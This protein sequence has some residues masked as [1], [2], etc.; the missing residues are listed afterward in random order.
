M[1]NFDSLEGYTLEQRILQGER[2]D[3]LL[4]NILPGVGG[5][6]LLAFFQGRLTRQKI[7]DYR[8]GRRWPP[9]W[10]IDLLRA[11]IDRQQEEF[12]HLVAQIPVAKGRASSAINLARWKANRYR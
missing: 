1:Q 5:N 10:T 3:K 6:K 2:F 11:E 7:C 9:K 4:R 12:K 8:K